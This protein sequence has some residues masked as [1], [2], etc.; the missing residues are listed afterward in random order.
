M[1]R[2]NKITILLVIIAGLLASN[3]YATHLLFKERNNPTQET[4][5]NNNNNV[6]DG[7][8]NITSDITELVDNTKNKVVSVINMK[9]GQ[10]AGSGSGVVYK[11]D[12]GR[13]L[14]VTNHHVI[15]GNTSV[16]VRFA[17]GQELEAKLLGSDQY[18]DLALLEVKDDLDIQPF[19]M[20]DSTKTKVGEYVIAIG[21]PLGIEFENSVTFGII[22]GVNRLIPVSTD[23]SGKSDWDMLVL[24]T[25][26]AINPGNSGGALVNMAG[27][28]IGINSLKLASDN[29][30][31]MGFSIPVSEM[32]P[33]I[34]QI[35]ET[36]K[37][38]YPIVGVSMISIEDLSPF[39]RQE[40]G[41]PT[42]IQE[43]ILVVEVVPNSPAASARIQAGDII[44]KFE[45]I[46]VTNFKDFRRELFKYRPGDKVV[47]TVTRDNQVIE[48]DVILGD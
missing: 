35:E 27:E 44:N 43:G 36:G 16:I 22:S 41:I 10:R 47:F 31:G 5:G 19:K 26:A 38:A 30:E 14:I 24:Q 37:V 39:S 4:T 33:I 28:L 34:Q 13:I 11:N 25:D 32:I 6:T 2:N 17:D 18:T 1:K 9:G 3:F 29:V 42:N 7:V 45:D 12:S 15:D 48:I 20:G 21:S 8:V 23:S 40:Y 46:T